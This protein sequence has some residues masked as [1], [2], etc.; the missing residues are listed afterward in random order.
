MV[1]PGTAVPELPADDAVKAVVAPNG[2]T[3]I[4]VE[5]IANVDTVADDS[6]VDVSTLATDESKS[7]DW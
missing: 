5:P 7:E 1:E 4:G 3:A 2:E 6:P